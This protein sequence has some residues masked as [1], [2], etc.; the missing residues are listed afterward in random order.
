MKKLIITFLFLILPSIIN[1]QS[2]S[3]TTCPGAGCQYFNTAGQGSFG[4]QITGTWVGTITFQSSLGTTTAATFTSLLVT[5][6]NSTTAVTTTTGNGVWTTPIAGINQVR[7]VF[8]AYTSGTA[9]ILVRTTTQARANISGGGG[10]GGSGTVTQIDTS[11]PIGG[12]PITTTGTIDCLTCGV[13]GSPLS[14][15]A[16]TTSA[17]LAGVIS[18]ETGTGSL[19]FGTGP[20]I[21][22][23]NGTGLPV[24]TGISGLGTG[25]ATALAVNT[26]SAGAFVL[27]NG[28]LG[29]P[30]SGTLTNT[31]GLPVSTGISGLGTNVATALAVN[32]GSAGAFVTF[33]G[34]LGTPSSGTLSNATGLPIS[35]G[36]SGL[37][38]NVATFLGT[39]SSANLA[40]ALTD[41]T[42]S[43]LAVFSTS[44]TLTTPAI[45]TSSTL[46]NNNIGAVSTDGF[47][48]QNTTAAAAGA[49]QW[50][51]RLHFI[52]QGWKTT[53]TAASQQV[54]WL[55]E[56]IP[57]QYT[58]NPKVALNVSSIVNGGATKLSFS[59]C[60]TGVASTIGIILRVDSTTCDSTGNAS[61]GGGIGTVGAADLFGFFS[62]A[63][64]PANFSI[65]GF[66]IASDAGIFWSST[67]K[68]S[69]NTGVTGDVGLRRNA[70]GL[71]DV[72]QGTAADC[73]TASNC[74]DVRLRHLIASGTAPTIDT[75]CGTGTLATGAS[76]GSGKITT[77]TTGACTIVL[78][79]GVAWARAPSCSVNNETT[80]N[81][82][83]STTTTTT[84]TLTGT[85]VSG[86]VWS[87]HCIGY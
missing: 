25:V 49:Q 28:V 45:T 30:S 24:S 11:S 40:S 53:A 21:T 10:G 43:A 29:T 38:A 70:A 23:A 12:G 79:F 5:P 6:S 74:R 75:G 87:Y 64:V 15:F 8:T 80:A 33:N 77:N 42:G 65:N 78:T 71:L 60:G 1:A 68:S 73:G 18:N 46:S 51:P 34:A 31:T 50:S 27:F 84:A 57:I 32:V 19:V 17:Q 9:N 14:Q 4:I 3:T 2:I 72:T 16:S 61:G 52:G 41:E 55:L 36:I 20:T 56:T 37:G 47:V 7:V 69:F 22:L 85:T 66:G 58:T 62:Q 39:P 86:D 83:R 13:T 35:T 67:N 76:D 48:I 82:S 63:N 54:E 44:P 26:G 59:V 81:L